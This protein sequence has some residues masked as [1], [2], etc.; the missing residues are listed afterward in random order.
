MFSGTGKKEG[1]L[2]D[3]M[4]VGKFFSFQ[5]LSKNEA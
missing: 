5:F 2:T 1:R 4:L 3:P